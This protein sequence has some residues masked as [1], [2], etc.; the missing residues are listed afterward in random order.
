MNQ[1]MKKPDLLLLLS[2]VVVLGGAVT[3]FSAE[4]RKPLERWTS[5]SSIR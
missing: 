2:V 5:E 4:E 3:S 1:S